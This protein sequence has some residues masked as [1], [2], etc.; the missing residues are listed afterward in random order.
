MDIKITDGHLHIIDS[1]GKQIFLTPE[2]TA[3]LVSYLNISLR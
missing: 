1:T 3:D 2:E